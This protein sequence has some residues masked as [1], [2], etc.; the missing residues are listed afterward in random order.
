ME[1]KYRNGI[2]KWC[3]IEFKFRNTPTWCLCLVITPLGMSSII[4]S[5]RSLLAWWYFIRPHMWGTLTRLNELKSPLPP[6]SYVQYLNN[7]SL[8]VIK[9]IMLHIHISIYVHIYIYIYICM[10]I[11]S[12]KR[13][14]HAT[15]HKHTTKS[16]I[17]LYSISIYL[18]PKTV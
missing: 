9:N 12:N 18:S 1:K 2:S 4:I 14:K 13:F 11:I 7:A 17:C 16:H 8:L 3:A 15:L 5:W 10:Y 6:H